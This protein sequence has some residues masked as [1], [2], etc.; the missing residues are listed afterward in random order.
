MKAK[1]A[2]FC[3]VREE[4]VIT[5]RDVDDDLRSADRLP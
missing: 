2:L 5:A 3:N 4:S 1:I